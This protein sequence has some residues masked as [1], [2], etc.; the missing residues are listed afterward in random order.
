MLK[1]LEEKTQDSPGTDLYLKTWGSPR[2]PTETS[3]TEKYS[4][5][6][7]ESVNSD[8]KRISMKLG[9]SKGNAY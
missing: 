6:G 2:D 7:N 9:L 4:R 1:F 3:F 8:S 5:G